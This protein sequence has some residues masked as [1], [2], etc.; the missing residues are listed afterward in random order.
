MAFQIKDDILD[1]EGNAVAL[2]KEIGQDV[3]VGVPTYPLIAALMEEAHNASTKK[4]LYNLVKT[5]KKLSKRESKKVVDLAIS[6]G[7]VKK[8]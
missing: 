1:Y 2:G 4:P 5:K 3:Q 7:G 6:L 8:G